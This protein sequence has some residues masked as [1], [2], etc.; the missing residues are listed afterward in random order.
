MSINI[1]S[2]QIALICGQ[3]DTGKSVLFRYLMA[4]FKLAGNP[5]LI[6]DVGGECRRSSLANGLKDDQVIYVPET[7]EVE[8][9][10]EVCAQVWKRGNMVFG[11]E[12]LDLF[13]TPHKISP[14]F[15]KMCIRHRH[16]GVGI[17]WTTRFFSDVHKLP[18]RLAKHVFIY[19]LFLPNDIKYLKEFV[20]EIAEQARGLPDYHFIYY[21][22][23]QAR[24][25]QPIPYTP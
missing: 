8:E 4:Q 13:T 12:E 21:H 17:V 6:Y 2:D 18:C 22:R 10:D 1:D 3:T 14:I 25:F 23:N 9:F 24:V 7:L 11:I 20:G 5:F 19:H 16:R 15:K